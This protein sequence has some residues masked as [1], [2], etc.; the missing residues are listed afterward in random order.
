MDARKPTN[1]L[2]LD[3]GVGQLSGAL[4]MN[5]VAPLLVAGDEYLRSGMTAVDLVGVTEADSAALSLLL[6]WKRRA[7]KAN[8]ML[9]F[10]NVPASLR[11]LAALYGVED[12]LRA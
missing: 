6:E 11:H 1:S 2:V 5:N 10:T 9:S 7:N 12:L 8:Q 4:V 3:A